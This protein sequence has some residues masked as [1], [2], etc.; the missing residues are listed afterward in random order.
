MYADDGFGQGLPI[1][2]VGIGTDLV[3]T[4]GAAMAVYCVSLQLNSTQ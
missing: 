2:C 3:W 1:D 4:G